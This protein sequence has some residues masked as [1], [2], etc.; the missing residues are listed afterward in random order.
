MVFIGTLIMFNVRYIIP[1]YLPFYVRL[2]I[3][4]RESPTFAQRPLLPAKI[5]LQHVV[6][7]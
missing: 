4:A 6:P 3:I 7:L 5:T 2:P 1:V